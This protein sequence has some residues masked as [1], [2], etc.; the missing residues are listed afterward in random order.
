M[1]FH[2]KREQEYE[3]VGGSYLGG[4]GRQF[5]L[6][7][8]TCEMQHLKPEHNGA[9]R[10]LYTGTRDI[11]TVNAEPPCTNSDPR[12]IWLLQLY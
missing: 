9:D 1:L 10:P 8:E 11:S 3:Q 7:H 2:Q 12:G 5:S 6:E 4:I